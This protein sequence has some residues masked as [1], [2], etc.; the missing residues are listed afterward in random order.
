MRCYEGARHHK[1]MITMGLYNGN[2]SAF[3]QA[4]D[5]L[6]GGH[7]Q[8][9]YTSH[10]STELCRKKPITK[11]TKGHYQAQ[12]NRSKTKPTHNGEQS[13]R[14]CL[15]PPSHHHNHPHHRCCLV[16]ETETPQQQA[17]RPRVCEH[18][19]RTRRVRQQ[20]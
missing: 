16:P 17:Q 8:H 12:P 3:V 19:A 10:R 1:D 9:G 18:W 11:S 14:C 15:R 5:I 4:H 2:G 13:L 20:S 6:E 7:T